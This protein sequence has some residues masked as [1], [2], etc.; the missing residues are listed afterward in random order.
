[1]QTKGK[2]LVSLVEEQERWVSILPKKM[3]STRASQIWP[4]FMGQ[5][6][7]FD[8]RLSC[9]QPRVNGPINNGRKT[10]ANNNLV[11]DV[12]NICHHNV[13]FKTNP[14][15]TP[16]EYS[17][18]RLSM[19][20][21]CLTCSKPI[22]GR[23]LGG[24]KKTNRNIQ[25]ETTKPPVVKQ[26][27]LSAIKSLKE[28]PK[29]FNPIGLPKPKK[30][31]ASDWRI[32]CNKYETENTILTIDEERVRDFKNRLQ[33]AIDRDEWKFIFDS[34]LLE[35]TDINVI[36]DINPYYPSYPP[37]EN[38]EER[39]EKN[40]QLRQQQELQLQYEKAL[41]K[42]QEQ[43]TQIKADLAKA[44]L[45]K[46]KNAQIQQE[47]EKL[48][49]KAR[50]FVKTIQ[51]THLA[52]KQHKKR[53]KTGHF[54]KRDKEK[55]NK[56]IREEE[57][58]VEDDVKN[59][60]TAIRE[61]TGKVQPT[62]TS[63]VSDQEIL[64]AKLKQR[65]NL[66]KQTV[67]VVKIQHKTIPIISAIWKH[68]AGNYNLESLNY[69][70]SQ[71]SEYSVNTYFD[72]KSPTIM[73]SQLVN[74]VDF[75]L[76]R[77]ERGLINVKASKPSKCLVKIPNEE[78]IDNISFVGSKLVLTKPIEP[79]IVNNHKEI[80]YTNLKKKTLTINKEEQFHVSS[81][82]NWI[83]L[84][85]N[86]NCDKDVDNWVDIL[87]KLETLNPCDNPHDNSIGGQYFT[88]DAAGL[89]RSQ[90]HNFYTK[91]INMKLKNNRHLSKK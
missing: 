72:N 12:P 74:Y 76:A 21:F 67:N 79:I 84:L 70:I 59:Y 11:I 58:I 90:N 9:P 30:I 18:D 32:F 83:N 14:P 62:P 22:G 13:K 23:L 46:L 85:L 5:L 65:I 48:R 17:R 91:K 68:M 82:N 7:P 25:I 35:C 20:G 2:C 49:S 40:R 54:K 81:P 64:K 1:M 4:G 36:M 77:F 38:K 69:V 3:D 55:I 37:D 43:I 61:K 29:G 47:E 80:D 51:T 66:A 63:V 89:V 78:E 34:L 10:Y 60:L 24:S 15:T 57:A 44:E 56:V 88:K 45:I 75:M 39:K 73:W 33:N 31:T 6:N 71:S 87:Y 41:A 52:T 16:M 28:I 86:V 27:V 53:A 19:D 50:N 26:F 42:E 8:N